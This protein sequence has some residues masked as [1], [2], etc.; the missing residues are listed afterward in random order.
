MIGCQP[1]ISQPQ[2]NRE[3]KTIFG[4]VCPATGDWITHIA[5]RGNTKTFFQFLL[6]VTK[7]FKDKKVYMVLDNV[8]YHHAKRIKP[9]LER[10]KHR[11]ELVFLPAYSPDLNPVERIWWLMRKE[12][13]HN[14]WVKSMDERIENFNE[15][16][17]NINKEKIK[18]NCNLIVNI[19]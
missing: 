3:R 6:L 4:C 9:I 13:T 19:Y 8:R 2:R 11:I 18:K 10:Y 7:H 15:W 14:R 12:V 16:N 17:L 1:K 5:D